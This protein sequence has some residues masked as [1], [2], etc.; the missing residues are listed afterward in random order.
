VLHLRQYIPDVV[1]ILCIRVVP[2]GMGIGGPVCWRGPAPGC[3]QIFPPRPPPKAAGEAQTPTPGWQIS[4]KSIAL[5]LQA[6]AL[7]LQAIDACEIRFGALSPLQIRY[8]LIVFLFSPCP[9]KIRLFCR[10]EVPRG[11]SQRLT[12]VAEGHELR[13]SQVR[14]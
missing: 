11:E 10:P 6:I 2:P 4:R 3:T 7:D 9:C 1:C 14:C 12:E 8:V 13:E 5:D